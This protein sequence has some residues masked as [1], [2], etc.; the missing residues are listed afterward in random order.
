MAAPECASI[1][2]LL[3]AR[4][5]LKPVLYA[6]PRFAARLQSLAHI[7]SNRPSPAYV[8]DRAV[9]WGLPEGLLAELDETAAKVRMAIITGAK[10]DLEMSSR[11]R[12]QSP[13]YLRA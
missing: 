9:D 7:R 13:D 5:R 11:I 10:V 12:I 2:L 3:R 6:P 8:R 1:F 4:F